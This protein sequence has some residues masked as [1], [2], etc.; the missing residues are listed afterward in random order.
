LRLRTTSRRKCRRKLR[1]VL[2]TEDGVILEGCG[3][4]SPGIRVG[5]LV[6]TT[7][8]VGYPE[9]LTDPSYKGQILIITHPL[10]GN[11]GVPDRNIKENGIPL[12]YESDK[13]QVEALVVAYETDPSHWASTMSLHQWLKSEGIPGVSNV[14]TRMLVEHI[15][16]KG[17]V[18]AVV[19]VYPENEEIDIEQLKKILERT[20]R[21]DYKNLVDMVAP[22]KTI[23]HV[24]DH[25]YDDTVVLIDCG[26]K[27]GIVRELL[28]RRIRV[29]RI[30]PRD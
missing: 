14:D 29:I 8:M 5:E 6:F 23:L 2:L 17:T 12:H 7:G 19:A 25:G 20:E 10:I 21:Y 15:R 1:S 16:E 18:M 4:G 3:F 22:P 13:I 11:Y 27:Y 30:P 28:R 9:S 26:V 24:P